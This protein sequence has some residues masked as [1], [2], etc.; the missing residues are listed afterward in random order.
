MSADEFNFYTL[1]N[2]KI[3][4]LIYDT[5]TY[6]LDTIHHQNLVAVSKIPVKFFFYFWPM[7]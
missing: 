4:C 3:D 7:D 5:E 1:R 2:V 6:S